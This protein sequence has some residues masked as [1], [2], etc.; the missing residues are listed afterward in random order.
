M[1]NLQGSEGLALPHRLDWT[2]VLPVGEYKVT[3]S[4]RLPG[5]RLARF[6]AAGTAA[7]RLCY[8]CFLHGF[9][10][11]ASRRTRAS[12]SLLPKMRR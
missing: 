9:K 4:R 3:A 5:G 10:F 6:R 1:P 7:P 8:I 2:V 12:T 11:A